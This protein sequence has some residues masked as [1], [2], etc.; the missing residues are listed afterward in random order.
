MNDLLNPYIAGAPV[1]ETSMFFGREE[2]FRWIENSLTGKYVNHILVIH[3]QRRVGKT[4]VLKQ[5]PNFL[6]EKYIQVF[7]DLQGRTSTTL[8]RFLWWMASEIL[9]TLNKTLKCDLPRIKRDQFSESDTFITDF[10]PSLKPS[11]DGHTLLLTFDEFDSLSRE[12]I[13]ETLARP[14]IGFLRRL[15][16]I[17]GLNFIFSIGS[18]G[19][20]LENM[21]AAYTDFFKTALYRKISFL[22]EDDCFNLITKPV[23]DIIT[24][25]PNAI[26]RITEI[27]SGHPYFTQ[28]TCHEL[29]SRCQINGSRTI[30]E[31]DVEA[32]LGDVIERGTVNLKFVWDEASDIEKWIL[33]VLGKEEGLSQKLIKQALQSQGVRFSVSDLNSAILHLR[34]KDVITKDNHLIIHLMKQWLEINRP[35][36][37]VREELVQTNPI[38]DRYVEIGDEYRERERWEDAI[39]SYEQALTM[40]ANNLTALVNIGGI[41]LEQGSYQQAA[42]SY[43]KALQVDSEHIAARQGYCQA[44]LSLGDQARESGNL[45]DAISAYQS[46]LNLTPVHQQARQ[47]LAT[48]YK[49]QAE[50]S[51]SS[52]DDQGALENLL[53]AMEMT[54]KDKD[55]KARHQQIVDEKKAALIKT[56]TDKVEKALKRNRWDEAVKMAQEALNIDPDDKA[57]QQYLAEIKDA[58]R[59]EK[60]KAYRQ[61]AEVAIS[62]GNY[63]KAIQ[64]LETAI[65]LAPEDTDLNAW[66]ASIRV[67]QQHA[68]LRLYQTQAERAQASGDWEAAIAAREQAVKLDPQDKT[69]AE[70]LAKTKADYKDAQLRKYQMRAETAQASGDWEA[71]IS[72]RENAIKL[73]PADESLAEA[74]AKTKADQK[75]ALLRIYQTQAESAQASGDWEAAIAAREQAIQLAPEDEK[76]AQALE[77]TIATPVSYTH[78]TLPTN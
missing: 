9:R 57:L 58:P 35:I 56:W 65:L 53:L 54:P 64:A 52:G 34:D 37:R 22:T 47:N 48:I 26:Q 69:L 36:E 44:Q 45:S 60:L 59:Q 12:D 29:F 28:L 27:T 17:E 49:D 19:N 66:L 73:D 77:D 39:N 31:E 33:S 6:P 15:F 5:I 8:D 25:Q 4:T 78:L 51:L 14:L 46:I 11:L 76:F 74:L 2:V 42:T 62:K 41:Y 32:I 20:K 24:Y 43:E 40:Q 21:Q 61:D 10:I 63:P 30:T 3:G 67:D 50:A 75:H 71:A 23:A 38:A 68:Q 72:A 16:D 13:Q 1:V 7:F 55:L 70:A 18:S